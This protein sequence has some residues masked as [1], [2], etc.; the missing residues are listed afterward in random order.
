MVCILYKTIVL[1]L[2]SWIHLQIIPKYS[3]SGGSKLLHQL[4]IRTFISNYCRANL[5]CK[6]HPYYS[7]VQCIYIKLAIIFHWHLKIKAISIILDLYSTNRLCS[8]L[9]N[10]ESLQCKKVSHTQLVQTKRIVE[11]Q[12]STSSWKTWFLLKV[13]TEFAFLLRF[14]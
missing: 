8:T 13:T 10:G 4:R 9:Q 12:G 2:S 3:S 6:T 5:L 11:I 7:A 14:T 1:S